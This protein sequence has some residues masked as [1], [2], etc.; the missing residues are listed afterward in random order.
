M[1][2][3]GTYARY[4]YPGGLALQPAKDMDIYDVIRGKWNELKN[5]EL[6]DKWHRTR[7]Q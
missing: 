3:H 5:R 6:E 1:D 7:S 2:S 4:K